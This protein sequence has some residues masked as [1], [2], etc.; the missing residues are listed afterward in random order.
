MIRKY[1]HAKFQAIPGMHCA[2]NYFWTKNLTHFKVIIVPKLGKSADHNYNLIS[3]GG[4]WDTYTHAKLQAIP[5]MWSAENDQEQQIWPF[6]QVTI[7]PK[8]GTANHDQ[9][10]I[11]SESGQDTYVCQ[12]SGH[13]LGSAE[14][15]QNPK[16]WPIFTNFF[17]FWD[18]DR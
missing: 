13:S 14:N 17:G 18:V 3:S 5:S 10:L 1:T 15:A 12:I 2:E 4:G 11:S 7:A 8:F 9:D 6:L 16:V